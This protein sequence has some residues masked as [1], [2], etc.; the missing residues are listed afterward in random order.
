MNLL[1]AFIWIYLI[2]HILT[3][4]KIRKIRKLQSLHIIDIKVTYGTKLKIINSDYVPD[5]VYING[6]ISEIDSGGGISIP[7]PGTNNVTLVWEQKKK[8]YSKLF[9]NIESIIEI[10]FTDF[11][12]SDITLMSS[13]FNNCKNLKKINF[14]NLNTSLVNNMSSM[15]ENCIS[16]TSLDLSNFNTTNLINIE[17]MFKSCSSLKTLNL[18]NFKTPN[19]MI[20][21][22]LFFGCSS[23]ID[24]DISNMDTSSVIYMNSTFY[25]CSSLISINISNF[26]TKNVIL[27]DQMFMNC[28]SLKSLNLSNFVTSN[29]INMSSMFSGCISLTYLNLSNFKTSNVVYMDHMFH[30]CLSLVSLDLS[31]FETSEVISMSY[32]FSQC[33]LLVSLDLSNFDISQ[34]NLDGLFK[35][36]MS[37]KTIKFSDNYTLLYKIDKMFYECTSLISINLYNF[38]FGFIDNMGNLF[39]SCSSL[40]SL[41]LSNVDPFSVTNMEFMFFN[42]ISLKFLIIKNWITS[43]VTDMKYM[44]FNCK[45]LIS[46]DLSCFNTSQV[47]AMQAIFY[48][49]LNLISLNLSNFDTSLVTNMEYMFN[50]CKSLKSLD[51]SSFNT[52]LVISMNYMFNECNNLTILNLSNFN[53]ENTKEINFMFFGCK[54]IEYIN[55][56]NFSKGNF[57]NCFELFNGIKD[58]IVFCINSNNGYS[59]DQIL[60]QI[61]LKKC[62]IID[63]SNNWKENKNKIIEKK[64]ICIDNCYNDD[65]YKYEYKYDCY[66]KCPKGTHSI[67]DNTFHCEKNANKCNANYPYISKVDNSCLEECHSEDFFNNICTINN[68][69]DYKNSQSI[70]ISTIIKEIQD[71]SLDNLLKKEVFY[72]QNDIIK[73]DSDTLYQITSPFIQKNTDYQNISI[74]QLEE[75]EKILKE[76]YDISQ[77]EHLIIFKIEQYI[78]GIL[79]PL[80]QYEIFNPNTRK[81]LDLRFCINENKKIYLNIPVYINENI[82]MKY[83]PNND[84]YK[85]ICYPYTTDIG[86]DINLYDRQNEFNQYYSIC[87]KN[88][89]FKGYNIIKSQVICH[90]II[91]NGIFL[92]SEYNKSELTYKLNLKSSNIIDIIKCHKLLFSKEG[93][94]TNFG[95]YII[96]LIIIIYLV[97]S[98]IFYLKEYSSILV[99]INGLLMLKYSEMNSETIKDEFKENSTDFSSSKKSKITD[100]KNIFQ[101][102]NIEKKIDSKMGFYINTSNNKYKETQNKKE[103]EKT[104]EYMDY[105]LNFISFNEALENDK[106]NF[107]QYYI[108]LLKIKHILLFTFNKMNDY[109]SFIIKKCLFFFYLAL[110][111]VV[112]ALFFNDSTIHQIYVEKG[113]F[114][115]IYILPQI[116]YSIIIC[117]IFFIIIRRF[118]LIQQN[119]MKIK[120]ERNKHNFN[121]IVFVTLKYINIKLKLFFV[122]C[123]ILLIFFW[124]YLSCFCAVFKNTQLYLIKT[125]LISYVISFIY[126]FIIY[127]LPSFF[128]IFSFKQP[129]ECL[130]K[131]SQYIL[132]F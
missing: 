71:G 46:L 12:T 45:S 7:S 3:E 131:I 38:D 110:Y 121:T 93:L 62:P 98:F 66:D 16:L 94:I 54:N 72:R 14:N 113:N 26:D 132:I 31:Q 40:T 60:S 9:K 68:I 23:L 120:Q 6:D 111:L 109:N 29:V 125:T 52:S 89:I 126:P 101:K 58:N 130:Y 35:G 25:D 69:K 100:I 51:L 47:K 75:C 22:D 85:E 92:S 50:G 76:K 118:S 56:Y 123:L 13:M 61:K 32:M 129:G 128:R 36:C 87:P 127:L 2:N 42:C 77:N 86:T 70:L 88:C 107:F 97:S 10:N 49:C 116:L 33:H 53:I 63:C 4:K 28:I 96:I 108:S 114:N 5:R 17:S 39:Y 80:I 81:K 24:I 78:E 44:F 79:I 34:K 104:N 48:N 41:D 99:Q 73:L 117:S 27:M 106:R 90:C 1:W 119:V 67:K 21:D 102:S 8:K 65:T 91:K 18:S 64:K 74:I 59:S 37:L 11:D 103:I 82:S 105:E 112:N 124:Y 55:I 30:G 20:M 83:D 15:F 84:F 122:I 57:S 19:L 43:F 115:F 95:N